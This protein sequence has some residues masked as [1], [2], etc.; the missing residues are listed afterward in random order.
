MNL[1]CTVPSILCIL[2]VHMA[3]ALPVSKCPSVCQCSSEYYVYC[4]SSDIGDDQLA[5]VIRAVPST[6]VLLDLSF[7]RI[8]RLDREAFRTLPQ[9]EILNLASNHIKELVEGVFTGLGKLEELNLRG[10]KVSTLSNTS[11]YGLTSLKELHL[12]G[13]DITTLPPSV[14]QN[15]S[16]LEKLH[17]Q[18]NAIIELLPWSFI[19]L[20]RLQRLN[21]SR[22]LLKSISRNTFSGLISLKRLS[23]SGNSISEIS[24]VD[25]FKSLANLEELLLQDNEIDNVLF[26]FGNDF[27]SSLNLVSLSGNKI[28]SIP[29][30]VFPNILN[31]KRIDLSFNSIRHIGGQSFRNLYL[32]TLHLHG[33]NL[34]EV[35]REMFDGAR[36]ISELDL[37]RNRIDDVSTGAFDSFRETLLSLDLHS[38]QLTSVHPGMFRGMRRLRLCNM[39]ANVI[40][41]IEQDSF[42][43][44]EKLEELNLSGNKFT[45]L[46]AD[47]ISGPVGL[48]KLYLVCNPMRKLVGFVFDDVADKIFIET[49]STMLQPTSDSVT[50]TWPYT[51]GS[52]LYWT[53]SVAC[54]TTGSSCWVPAYDA[55]LR[56]YVTQVTIRDL[57]PNA[58]YF[59]C[60]SPVF[61]S[62]EVNVSQCVHVRT[63]QPPPSN[64]HQTTAPYDGVRNSARPLRTSL[65]H[66]VFTLL[67]LAAPLR[68]LK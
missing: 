68:C 8:T 66:T 7:N 54:I 24:S 46:S 62:T 5:G 61:L 6:A 25:A 35:S 1:V 63:Q 17:L 60:V 26:M 67:L 10:N 65:F 33:N 31:L 30:H 58:D 2:L 4:Q 37:S 64:L 16:S 36:R 29:S 41:G 11:F 18:R 21:L 3:S 47:S 48:R 20:G 55:T 34:T 50:V 57:A 59:V 38:N 49:N 52:Q 27:Y 13:N 40:S 22:N 43:D 23:L 19:G 56:P 15:L 53:L 28:T 45:T 44:L 39:A 51:E 9:L 12:C 42:K 32:E 14:F